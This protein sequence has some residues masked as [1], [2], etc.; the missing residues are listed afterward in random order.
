M[1]TPEEIQRQYYTET[2]TSYD[3]NHLDNIGAHYVALQYASK[4]MELAEISS[5]LDVG[6][7][8]GRAVKH[9]LDQGLIVHGVEP[10]QALIDQAV[11]KHDIPQSCLTCD[12]GDSLPFEDNSFDAVCEFG[13]LH[14]VANPN[15]ILREMMRVARKMVILSDSNRFGQGSKIGRWTKL[16]LYKTNTWSLINRV[17]TRGRGYTISQGDGLAYSY[18]IFDSFD[19]L[20]I[21]ADKVVVLST[22][23]EKIGSWHHPLLTSSHALLCATKETSRNERNE[24]TADYVE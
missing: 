24:L 23:N 11:H 9:F 15:L 13:V 2:A 6:C 20:T 17:K 8:T 5:V 10:V 4:L 3:D 7:G 22:T 21:W 16:L 19:A 1:K 14:H 18:S 12:T